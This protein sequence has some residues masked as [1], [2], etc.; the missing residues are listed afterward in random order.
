MSSP[1]GAH[2]DP[3]ERVERIRVVVADD[4]R[5]DG[6]LHLVGV[7]G[8]GDGIDDF[9]RAPH[10]VVEPTAPERGRE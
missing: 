6:L 9:E 3:T 1:R 7:G 2:A 10:T 4:G 8:V 5:G